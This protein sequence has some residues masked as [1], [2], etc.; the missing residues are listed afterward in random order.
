MCGEGGERELPI[1]ICGEEK[2]WPTSQRHSYPGRMSTRSSR[3]LLRGARRT[4]FHPSNYRTVLGHWISRKPETMRGHLLLLRTQIMHTPAGTT[5]GPHRSASGTPDAARGTRDL[6]SYLMRPVLMRRRSENEQVLGA[7]AR[8]LQLRGVWTITGGPFSVWARGGMRGLLPIYRPVHRPRCTDGITSEADFAGQRR[9]ARRV[10]MWYRQYMPSCCGSCWGGSPRWW[11]SSVARAACRRS[12]GEPVWRRTGWTRMICPDTATPVWS[13]PAH[14]GRR[15]LAGHDEE[16]D[17]AFRS[18]GHR[19]EPPVPQ[20]YSTVLADGS[21]AT[22]SPGLPLIAAS[23]REL[24]LPFCGWRTSWGCGRGRARGADDRAEGPDM[25]GLPV[26]RGRRCWTSFDLHL[27]EALA[28]GGR[29]LRHRCCL[30]PRRRWMRLDPLSADPYA[31]TVL[32]RG[33]LYPVQGRTPSRSSV[34]ENAR[35]MCGRGR[36]PHMSWSGLA[37]RASRPT[38]GG[39]GD[40]AQL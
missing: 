16:R 17:G 3:P 7:H 31:K 19:S 9:R 37:Q 20:P 13:G 2:C 5:A 39:A 30:G 12:S 10:L 14:R 8:F 24:G 22:A 38:W 26:D 1:V 35:A 4:P 32:C 15:L 36:E 6:E 18:G 25:F 29:K 21:T 27:D 33:N 34:E 40:W 23:L 11:T 28:E